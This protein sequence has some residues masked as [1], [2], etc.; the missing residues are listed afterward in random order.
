MS[1]QAAAD[2]AAECDRLARAFGRLALAQVSGAIVTERRLNL[3]RRPD[4]R[5]DDCE[6]LRRQKE[7]GAISGW[8]NGCVIADLK[9]QTIEEWESART[10]YFPRTGEPVLNSAGQSLVLKSGWSTTHLYSLVGANA[11]HAEN[12][13]K[14]AGVWA[15]NRWGELSW[16]L[17]PERGSVATDCCWPDVVNRVS[18]VAGSSCKDLP[19]PRWS[20]LVGPYRAL[21]DVQIWRRWKSSGFLRL[22]PEDVKRIGDDPELVFCE[23]EHWLRDSETALEWLANRL[24]EKQPVEREPERPADALHESGRVLIW[25]GVSYSLTPNQFAV[26]RVLHTAYVK[27][28][29]DVSLNELRNKCDIAALKDESF[30][31]VFQVKRGGK[32]SYNPV[33]NVI[34]SVTQGTYRL[35]DPKKV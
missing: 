17:W 4:G 35:S 2:M 12:L 7:P 15:A 16:L 34:V 21:V 8:S 19:R 20:V 10:W 1:N 33:R 22:S 29:P 9:P 3:S 25:G 32:K 26:V 23:R 30:A 24:H 6:R 31:K 5:V 14:Q 13:L 28:L 27:G 11:A 18:E